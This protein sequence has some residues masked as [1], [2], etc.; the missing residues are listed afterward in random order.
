MFA[1]CGAHNNKGRATK[2]FFS[3]GGEGV[4]IVGTAVPMGMVVPSYHMSY[5][6]GHGW[7]HMVVSS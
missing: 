7:Y 1:G 4:G 3:V 6:H 2:G 5:T